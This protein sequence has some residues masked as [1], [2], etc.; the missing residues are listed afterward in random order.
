MATS[1]LRFFSTLLLAGLGGLA[2]WTWLGSPRRRTREPSPL[3]G[4]PM[5]DPNPSEEPEGPSRAAESGQDTPSREG[6]PGAKQRKL[7]PFATL[8]KALGVLAL[9]VVV[10]DLALRGFWREAEPPVWETSTLDT[11]S[12]RRAILRHGCGGCH[13]IPGIRHATGRVGPSLRGIRDQMFIAGV[14]SNVPEN[15]AAW[16]QEPQ[17]FNSRTAM[18]NLGVTGEEARAIAIYL[19]SQP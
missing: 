17:R 13:V 18:P 7:P 16:I 6:A 3:P 19:Y 2:F 11:D 15:L 5:A 9:V 8:I 10:G 14:L 12:G 4:S 1:W